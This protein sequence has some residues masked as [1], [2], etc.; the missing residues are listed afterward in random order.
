ML[1]ERRLRIC[2]KEDELKKGSR[3][4]YWTAELAPAL[5]DNGVG[6]GRILRHG[7]WKGRG[8]GGALLRRGSGL[9]SGRD[10][11]RIGRRN[12]L[13]SVRNRCDRAAVRLQFPGAELGRTRRD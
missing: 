13:L 1:V 2:F 8:G 7:F 9:V 3:R 12:T 6:G 5:D 4:L 10:Q 11:D